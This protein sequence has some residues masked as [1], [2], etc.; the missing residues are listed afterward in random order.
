[1]GRV[2]GIL[3]DGSA[4]LAAAA[5]NNDDDEH[6]N[7]SLKPGAEYLLRKL[8]Y[9]NIHTAISYRLDLSA[10]KVLLYCASLCSGNFTF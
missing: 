2:R 10:H 7:A 9:S 4:L 6:V 3:L 5:A 1:M 8:S